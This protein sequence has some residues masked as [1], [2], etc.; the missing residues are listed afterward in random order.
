MI[1]RLLIVKYVICF[2][3]IMYSLQVQHTKL[4]GC[5]PVFCRFKPSWSLD[6]LLSSFTQFTLA[7]GN[8]HCSELHLNREF[9]VFEVK[10]LS[11]LTPFLLQ[12]KPKAP[13]TCVLCQLKFHCPFT[14]AKDSVVKITYAMYQS[15]D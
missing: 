3:I 7:P 5:F 8:M 15:V 10:N 13:T 4:F 11:P 6:L 9:D 12:V 1:Q 2:F 14:E